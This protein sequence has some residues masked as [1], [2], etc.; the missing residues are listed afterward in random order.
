MSSP[1]RTVP[2]PTLAEPQSPSRDEPMQQQPQQLTHT[3]ARGATSPDRKKSRHASAAPPAEDIEIGP[4]EPATSQGQPQEP[5]SPER[6]QHLRQALP[7]PGDAQAPSVQ[8]DNLDAIIQGNQRPEPPAIATAESE[9]DESNTQRQQMRVVKDGKGRNL[10]AFHDLGEQVATLASVP[11]QSASTPS[12][13]YGDTFRWYD[14]LKLHFLY[15]VLWNSAHS[16]FIVTKYFKK[17]GDAV[18]AAT[19]AVADACVPAFLD[20]IDKI[21]GNIT[22][23]VT[24]GAGQKRTGGPV[25]DLAKALANM[26]C[27]LRRNRRRTRLRLDR[28]GSSSI[29]SV[30]FDTTQS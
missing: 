19:E 21:T 12:V 3:P 7:D 16:E 11:P 22:I 1:P 8:E 18:T 20:F 9:D 28:R 6:M 13:L 27:I 4:S 26:R 30:T 5:L 24:L 2:D 10:V 14:L 23:A 17:G 29:A 25:A 15:P